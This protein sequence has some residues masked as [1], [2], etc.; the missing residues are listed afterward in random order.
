MAGSLQATLKSCV[1]TMEVNLALP[2]PTYL[3][4]DHSNCS[5]SVSVEAGSRWAASIIVE[6]NVEP[7]TPGELPLFTLFMSFICR[8]LSHHRLLPSSLSR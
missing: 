5:P 7:N 1:P 2:R 8:N 6:T 4:I 3:V